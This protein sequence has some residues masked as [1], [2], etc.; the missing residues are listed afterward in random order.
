MKEKFT[1]EGMNCA[2]CS[3]AVEKAVKKLDGVAEANVNLLGKSMTVK[4][5]ENIINS[6]DIKKSV[7]E[8]G[9]TA[10]SSDKKNIQAQT[11]EKNHSKK[12]KAVKTRLALSVFFLV[13]LMYISMGHM[14]GLP[15][16]SF[17]Q[18]AKNSVTFAFSQFL[19]TI[20]I[21]FLN[22][23][24]YTVGFK[25]LVNKTPNM[26]SLIAISSS[27][28]L[29]Y[30]IFSIFMIGYGLG[31]N[32]Y[33]IVHKYMENLYFETAAMILTL[34]SIGKFLEERSKGKTSDAIK[35]L[36]DLSPKTAVVIRNGKET[37]I[38][39][40]EIVVGDIIVVKPGGR[41]PVDGVIFEGSTAVD[42]SAL[43]GESIP[44]EKATG[45]NV[46]SASINKTGFFKMKAT[47][48]GSNTTL[49][50]IISLVEDA[51]ATKAP[52]AKLADRVSGVFVPIV[53]SISL[54][55]AIAWLILGYTAEFSLSI[56]ISVLVISCPCALGLA[57]PVAIMVATGK[58]ATKGI[59]I[60]SAEALETAHSVNTVVLDKTGTVT[61]GKPSV[62]DIIPSSNIES[63]ELIRIAASI[64]KLS[65]HPL[66]EAIVDYAYENKYVLA[67]AENFNAIPGKGITASISGK[68]YFAGNAAFLLENNISVDEAK[69]KTTSLSAQGKTPLLFASKNCLL[70]IIAV[71]DTLKQTSAE[72]VKLLKNMGCEVIMLTGDNAATA[73][74]IKS[75]VGID[76]VIS[77]VLP[78]QKEAEIRKLQEKGKKVAMVGDGIND[79]PALVRADVGIAIGAGSD[80]AIE[81]AGIV[82]MKNDLRD[83]AEV[84][85]YSKAT[86]RN[87]K[88]NLFWAFIYNSLGI[89]LAA[90]VF[91]PLFGWTLNP[92][93]GA[94]AMS[95][96]SVFVVTNALRLYKK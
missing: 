41:I 10:F 22:K 17:M 28:A 86:I 90:G 47:R 95:L 49:A 34:I 58:S 42:Q 23:K 84:I 92:M 89:P 27:A 79:S 51:S 37:E 2:A 36:I 78:S 85:R 21:V 50:Q 83:V 63:D 24:Y 74:A 1:V 13:I 18:G 20:P 3:A 68:K 93:I 60:K 39:V 55:S 71:A 94:A 30:G 48:V 8:A 91:Y 59:L 56:G 53:I 26:D 15:L 88:Q 61:E 57:T 66:A 44:L 67:P 62:T 6:Q 35:K 87:I 12:L 76:K 81:S 45:D 33:D 80:I 72:A 11:P 9:F 40:E 69:G 75:Q 19:L 52:I 14:I 77:D 43:T 73:E 31:H 38:P 29:F 5:D 54:I 64:E 70:G 16:P 32:N 4:F 46:M 65:E 25:A 82:L 96:S 7:T